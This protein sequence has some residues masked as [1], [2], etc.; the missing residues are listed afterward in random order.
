[1]QPR[2]G[3]GILKLEDVSDYSEHGFSHVQ[4]ALLQCL[5]GKPCK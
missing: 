2:T 5:V 4:R 1:M 3:L